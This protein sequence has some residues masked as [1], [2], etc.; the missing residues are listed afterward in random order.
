MKKKTYISP[1]IH[2]INCSNETILAGSD[3]PQVYENEVVDDNVEQY[4]K[5]H[6]FNF[7]ES[8]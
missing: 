4:G 3:K 7:L 6:T 1:D 2:V 8:E 5:K